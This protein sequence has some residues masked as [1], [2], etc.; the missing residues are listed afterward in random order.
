MKRLGDDRTAGGS[1]GR[2]RRAD[3][4]RGSMDVPGYEGTPDPAV[5]AMAGAASARQKENRSRS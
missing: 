2:G 5:G 4:G 3:Y 1:S